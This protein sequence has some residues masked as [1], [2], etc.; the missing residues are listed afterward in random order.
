MATLLHLTDLHLS[1]P[2]KETALGDYSKAQLLEPAD[3]QSRMLCRRTSV[4]VL[5][6]HI[7]DGSTGSRGDTS[8]VFTRL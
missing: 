8:G 5:P 7:G 2:T 3:F 4:T 1:Q 6:Q